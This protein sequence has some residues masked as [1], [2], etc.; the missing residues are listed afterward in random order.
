MKLEF[1]V[2]ADVLVLRVLGDRQDCQAI[3]ADD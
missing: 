1:S 2:A 3:L